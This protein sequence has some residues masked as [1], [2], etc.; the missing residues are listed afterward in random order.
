VARMIPP[1]AGSDTRSHGEKEVF[2]RLRNE[3]GTED[4]I[5]LHS[6][7]IAEH[8]TQPAGEADF[9]IIVPGHGILCLEVKGCHSLR[10]ENGEWYYG[11]DSRPDRRGP[12]RQAAN[13]MYSIKHY[14][15]ERDQRLQSLL[16]WSA[17]VFPYVDVPYESIEWQDWQLIDRQSF[18]NAPLAASILH[19]LECAHELVANTPYAAWYHP[20]KSRPSASNSNLAAHMLRPRFET[21]QSPAD[22]ARRRAEEIKHFTEE[23]FG[24]L[25]A[26]EDNERVVFNGPAG[27]GKTLLAI[28]AARRGAAD[29]KTVLLL[30]FNRLLGNWLRTQI[31]DNP[32]VTVRTLHAHMLAVLGGSLPEAATSAYWTT[33]LPEQASYALLDA[34]NGDAD[35]YD[36]LVVDEAQD[37]LVPAYLDFLELCLSGGLSSGRWLMFGDFELQI[38][39]GDR[40]STVRTILAQ[41]LGQSPRFSLRTNCRNTPRIA[42]TVRLLGQMNPGYKRILR[43]DNWIEPR[44]YY[45][46]TD[47]QKRKLLAKTLDGLL[48]EGFSPNDIVILTSDA[49]GTTIPK[50]LGE[51][52]SDRLLSLAKSTGDADR[53]LFG[54]IHSF[55]GMEA[56]AVVVTG[57]S[58]ITTERSV[59]LLYIGLSRALHRLVILFSDAVQHDLR[60][61]LAAQNKELADG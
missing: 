29:G 28:E 20:L 1:R 2:E 40:A 46:S 4:W 24:A 15:E 12:F 42:E 30:C 10:R 59:S 27:T 14:L 16:Y 61:L 23:Q 41:R 57:V 53:I 60:A 32:R 35:P 9:V 22:R 7:D 36:L 17:V 43:P 48:E 3:S 13:A 58:D 47:N 39:Y 55:K 56:P 49:G 44:I 11:R 21:Y 5:V 33:I 51:A 45:Y 18:D 19:V 54:S 34:L 26:M 52:W 38:I 6:L 31:D 25:D 37:I 50:L 8:D